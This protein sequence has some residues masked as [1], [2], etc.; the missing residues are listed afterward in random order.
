M[1]ERKA[2]AVLDDDLR[3]KYEEAL[4]DIEMLQMDKKVYFDEIKRRDAKIR[5]YDV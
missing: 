1:E 3:E 2:P 4:R 5:E